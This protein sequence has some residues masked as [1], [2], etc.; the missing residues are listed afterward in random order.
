M[1]F[2]LFVECLSSHM[3][4]FQRQIVISC[5]LLLIFSYDLHYFLAIFSLHIRLAFCHHL[6]FLLHFLLSSTPPSFLFPVFGTFVGLRPT[7]L[8]LLT[9]FPGSA[10]WMTSQTPPPST[11]LNR[12]YLPAYQNFLQ[13]AWRIQLFILAYY[14]YQLTIELRET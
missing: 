12:P 2:P 5:I 1:T 13:F 7:T 3:L 11:S 14:Q 6:R 9:T 8:L 4:L 10:V